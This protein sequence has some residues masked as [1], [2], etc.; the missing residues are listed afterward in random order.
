MLTLPL[1]VKITRHGAI[2]VVI[3]STCWCKWLPIAVTPS[4]MTAYCWSEF[5]TIAA[6][7][8]T[9]V[10]ADIDVLNMRILLRIITSLL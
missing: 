10:T 9:G 8:A 6:R 1:V 4:M 7:L 3:D 2:S 5:I